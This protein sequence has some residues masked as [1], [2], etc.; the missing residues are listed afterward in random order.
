MLAF[1]ATGFLVLLILLL[2]QGWL[3]LNPEH[4]PGFSPVLAFNTAASF[5]TNTNWQAYSGE[6]TAS[7]LAQTSGFAVQNFLSAA[8]GICISI[9]V[10]RGLSRTRTD[11]LGNFWVDVT[12]V[13]LYLLIPLCLVLAIFLV[14]QGVIQNYS[15]YITASPLDPHSGTQILPMGPVASQ[16]AIKLLG[17]NGEV[18]SMPTLRT[19]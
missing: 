11:R 9:A 13:T 12:R 1:N 14:S 7:Y 19:L 6:G 4:F 2:T 8:T 3:I 17:T 18:S 16:E 15:P 5:I 10:M